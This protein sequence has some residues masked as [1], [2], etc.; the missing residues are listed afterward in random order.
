MASGFGLWKLVGFSAEIGGFLGLDRCYE[1]GSVLLWPVL[2]V[3]GEREEKEEKKRN[4][5]KRVSRR[6]WGGSCQS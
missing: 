1:C 5:K 2:E 6:R 3:E 4:S